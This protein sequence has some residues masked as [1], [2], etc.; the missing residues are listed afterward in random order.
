[1]KKH[2]LGVSLLLTLLVSVPA[3][4]QLAPKPPA[5]AAAD[6]SEEAVTLSPFVV[7][8]ESDEGY[9][10]QQTMIGSRTAKNLLELPVAVSIIGLPQIED[11]A[12][13]DIHEVLKYG[14]SGVTRSQSFNNDVN[15]RGFRVLGGTLRNGNIA[16]FSNKHL[17]FF[18]IERV[19]VLKGPA[20]MLSGSN[21]GIG[22]TL[23]YFTR[24]P[25]D[26]P[27]GEVKTS[28][29]SA[30]RLRGQV[31]VSGPLY[32]KGESFRVNYRGTLGVAK[33]DTYLGK[34]PEW[35][36]QR[37]YAA[38][39]AMYFGNNTSLT[40][41]GSFDDNRTYIYLWD[42][43]DLSVPTNPRT[44]L[45]DAKL[46]RY[47]T[48]DYAPGRK[49]DAFWPLEYTDVSAT[50]LQT[51]TDNSNL[52]FVYN[53]TR[54]WDSRRNNRGITVRPDN[55][56]LARQDIRNDNGNVVHGF[57][58][59]YQ[60]NLVTKWGK[61]DSMVGADGFTQNGFTNESILLMPDAD[62]RTGVAPNDDAFYSQY[63]SDFELFDKARPATAG[64]PAT[65]NKTSNRN[66]SYYVQENVSF[67]KD[68]VILVGGLR[69][70][71]PYRNTLNRVTNVLTEDF[72]KKHRVHRYGIV[73]KLL[74]TVSA[75]YTDAQ[76]LFP[77]NPGR[78]DLVIQN[79]G[80]GEPFKD[81]E[82]KLQELGIKFD[83]KFSERV[84]GYGSAAFFKMEQTNI[85]TFGTL[86][87]G[88]QGL[89]QSAMDSAEGWE[90]DLGL[91]IKT[92]TGAVD[93]IVTYFNGDSAIALDKGKAYVRQANAFAPWKYSVFGRYSWTS[94][95]LRGFRFGAGFEDEDK[96]RNGAH[97]V[98]RPLTAD[99]FFGYEIN[100]RWDAQLNLSNITDELYIIQVAAT[101]LVSRE[102]QFRAKL[103]VTYKW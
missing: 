69:W 74:P 76:N 93:L 70:F 31:N 50:Y 26:K 5:D 23:N 57:Q 46:N 68:R 84:T 100:K 77:A 19:E 24:R 13:I 42:F 89:I 91:R 62:S 37:Y 67:L 35:E 75:Y 38:A 101:G 80:L 97:L 9:R 11:A 6:K 22:G 90:T 2:P 86:P 63:M 54:L 44:G 45:I 88:N 53:F 3:S 56:T 33:S 40:I 55:Y 8:N 58:F 18:D 61:L 96:R 4:A 29:N 65:K 47:S 7:S 41:E 102:D 81:S 32:R 72:V 78:T 60:H 17:P 12:A 43:L 95:T 99:A 73:V 103:T 85:R 92:E 66:L 64:T 14:T 10:T 52:R 71:K 48:L 34:D 28:I 79:D 16:R 27:M 98:D 82:G 51:L 59:D 25:T 36:D 30:G 49:K 87:S 39:L 94:G 21:S 83:Y 20:A 15:I 1:M